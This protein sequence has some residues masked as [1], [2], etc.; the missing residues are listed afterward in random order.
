MKKII[1]L[2]CSYWIFT[3]F[4]PPHDYHVSITQIYYDST[5]QALQVS[6]QLFGDDVEK[7][8]EKNAAISWKPL[9]DFHS[10]DSLL[11]AYIEQNF[12]LLPD[13]QQ[14]AAVLQYLG[15][16][17]D[18][19]EVWCYAEIPS[20]PQAPKHLYIKNTLL[21]EIFAQ[22]SN[23]IQANIGGHEK[24]VSLHRQQREAVL[25]F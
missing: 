7:A 20:L 22:Q 9:Q 25:E 16:E 11:R 12:K 3:A 19:D 21:T 5:T 15:F 2:F 24:S 6:I 13:S 14:Q 1:I 18:H 10:A 8:I 4:V 17:I 23:I